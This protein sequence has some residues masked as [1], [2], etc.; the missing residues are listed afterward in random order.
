MKK[1]MYTSTVVTNHFMFISS[2]ICRYQLS[3]LFYKWSQS[4]SCS[5]FPC[6]KT[7]FFALPTSG[8]S[9]ALSEVMLTEPNNV[10]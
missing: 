9:A 1:Y 7:H 4:V 10:E 3:H 8:F 5:S 2:F 6:L